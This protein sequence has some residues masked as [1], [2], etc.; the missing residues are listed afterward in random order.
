MGRTRVI[1]TLVDFLRH[2]G[3]VKR[4]TTTVCTADGAPPM[5]TKAPVTIRPF[6]PCGPVFSFEQQGV[7]R[8]ACFNAP[9]QAAEVQDAGYRWPLLIYLHGSRT[10]PDSLYSLGKELFALHDRYPLSDR[11]DVRGFFLLAPEG[12][13]ATPQ[14]SPTGTG[15][16]W[17]EWFRNAAENVDALAIDHFVDEAFAAGRIDPRRVYVFGWSNGAYMA[18]LYGVWRSSR[19]A[20]IGQ[21]AGADPWSRTPCPVPMQVDR[22]VPLVLL[23]NLCDSLVPCTTT[24]AWIETLT[25]QRWPFAAYNLDLRGRITTQ[26]RCDPRCSRFKGVYAH[27]RWPHVQALERM[28]AFFRAHPLP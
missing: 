28:L 10:T 19:I 9:H 14:E 18:A 2:A 15:F 4:T 23:R 27:V 24:G 3:G 16:H 20:A 5:Q 7:R 1:T 25:Q 26:Q 12:R 22:Q 17:D 13:R 8:Y 6:N 21:Y 11:A